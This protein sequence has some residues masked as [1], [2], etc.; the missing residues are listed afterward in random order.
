[1]AEIVLGLASAHTPQLHT[2]A[3]DW[4]IRADRDRTNGIELWYKGIKYLYDDLLIAREKDGYEPTILDLDE[5]TA[6]LEGCF[7][8]I[9]Q[10]AEIYDKVNPDI[11]IIC[12]N[13]QHE[14]YMEEIQPAFT[15]IGAETIENMPRTDDQKT[16]LPPGIEISDHGHL[17]DDYMSFKGV[18]D[19]ARLMAETTTRH[20]F[21]PTYCNAVPT[22]NPERNMLSGMPHAFGFIYRNIMHDNPIPHVPLVINSFFPPNRPS[23]KRCYEFGQAIGEAITNWKEDARV[24]AIASGGL[25]HFVIDEEF[26]MQF[27]KALENNDYDEIFALEDSWFRAGTSENKNWLMTAGILSH[28]DLAM[29]KTHYETLPRTEGG[30]GSTCGFA[31]WD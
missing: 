28:S 2:L 3:K 22:P 5:A 6:R 9:D 4:H 10:L 12:G 17:P 7:N 27:L 14:M 21:D 13:D 8:A 25:S 29:R 1:M 15:I 31:V 23:A 30:T 16:R 20:D 24:V 19:L 11:A 26:D 18:P